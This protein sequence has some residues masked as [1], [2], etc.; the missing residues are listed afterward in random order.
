MGVK[1]MEEGQK[2]DF[3]SQGGLAEERR[4]RF[5]ELPERTTHAFN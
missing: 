2:D 3:S 4:G 1:G 5:I